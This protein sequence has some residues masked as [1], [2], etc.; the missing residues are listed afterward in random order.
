MLILTFVDAGLPRVHQ[1][2]EGDNIIG[3]SPSC[4]LVIASPEI[5]RQHASVRVDGAR[6]TLRDLGSTLGTLVNGLPL[7]GDHELRVGDSF[8]LGQLPITLSGDLDQVELIEEG[9]QLVE[10]SRSIVMSVD[11]DGPATAAERRHSTDRRVRNVGRPEGDR[12]SGG[13]RRGGGLVRLLTEI[14]KSLVEVQ[15]LQQVLDRVVSLVFEVVQAERAFLLLRDGFDQPL[16]ARVMRNRDGTIPA[17]TTLSRTIINKVMRDRVAMLAKD[18]LYDPRLG[19]SGSIQL[20]NV[21]SFMCAPL[22]NREDVIGVLYCDNP[23][24]RKFHEHQLDVFAAV[25]NYA[26]VAIEQ[27]RLS[28][29]LAEETRRRERLQ[30]YHSPSVTNKILTDEPGDG[31]LVAQ[32]RDVSVMFCDIAGFTALTQH[33]TPEAVGAMLNEFFEC[34]T[35]VIFDHDGTLDKFIGDGLLAVFGAPF[36][37]PDHATRAVEAAIAMQRQLVHFNAGHP[38]RPIRVRIA[39]NSGPALTGDIGSRR[40]REF[41]VLG[42]VVNTASRIESSVAQPDQI[43]VSQYTKDR[44]GRGFQLRRLDSVTLRGRDSAIDMFEVI[45]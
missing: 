20:M 33:M 43:V 10:E 1:L 18:A 8:L 13:D 38:H 26:A 31:G 3:R 44:L 30:R 12:R 16:T 45:Q 25:C 5:S 35:D 9:H 42:D 32:T 6:I 17:R 29:Q 15:P 19:A 36:E 24:S 37:Q 27:S 39:I 7:T 11:W 2:R 14:G 23:R 41:T 34:M 21:R 4:E 28:G 22:W 40:R